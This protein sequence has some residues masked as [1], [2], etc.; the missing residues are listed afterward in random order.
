MKTRSYRT[1]GFAIVTALVAVLCLAASPAWA[2]SRA[3]ADRMSAMGRVATRAR[4]RIARLARPAAPRA[5]D[6]IGSLETDEDGRCVNEPDCED[7]LRDGPGR[8]QS[9]LSIAIDRTGQ[10]VVIGFND[11][12]GFSTSPVSISGF[13]Y[14]SDGGQTFTDGGQLPVTTGTTTVG[15]VLVP[16]VLGDPDV[17]YL[18]DCTF[19]Y[20]SILVTKLGANGLVQT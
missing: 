6:A 13:M 4:A 14:S 2:Q 15:G 20:S 3:N 5:A 12:R 8:T 17:V 18:G 19:V 16:Q 11:F 1:V 7:G 9:E 10:H